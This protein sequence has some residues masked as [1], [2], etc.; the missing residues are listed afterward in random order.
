[1]EELGEYE[2]TLADSSVNRDACVEELKKW[3]KDAGHALDILQV[4]D[5]GAGIFFTSSD[6]VF[7]AVAGKRFDWPW[8]E[9][10]VRVIRVSHVE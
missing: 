4:K 9:W 8:A 1:M 7:R 10:V 6:A 2:I 5:Y 3:A